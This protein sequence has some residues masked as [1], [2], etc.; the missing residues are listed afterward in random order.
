MPSPVLTPKKSLGGIQAGTL[1]VQEEILNFI[2][3]IVALVI[4]VVAFQRTGGG[5]RFQKKHSRAS[6]ENGKKDARRRIR[7]VGTI[8]FALFESADGFPIEY[9]RYATNII[10]RSL[11]PVSPT[12]GEPWILSLCITEQSMSE[13]APCD[14]I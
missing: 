10:P 5:Q 8:G 9:L 6:G 7:S 3:A 4:A 1:I 2:I 12:A 13:C 11:P 14:C